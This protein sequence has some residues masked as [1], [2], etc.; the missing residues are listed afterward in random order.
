MYY[1]YHK[2]LKTGEDRFLRAFDTPEDAIHHIAKCYRIDS[3]LCQLGEYYYFM[4]R[5]K[6][7]QNERICY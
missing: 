4:K 1:V 3:E 2:Y 6:E 5:D 7:S